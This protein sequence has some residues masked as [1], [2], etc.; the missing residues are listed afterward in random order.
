MNINKII[1][2]KFTLSYKQRE[3]TNVKCTKS[4]RI[5]LTSGSTFLTLTVHVCGMLVSP[6]KLG[7]IKYVTLLTISEP[8]LA[9][10]VTYITQWIKQIDKT[11]VG[12]M[13]I[14]NFY[15]LLANSIENWAIGVSTQLEPH[16]GVWNVHWSRPIEHFL[17]SF[18]KFYIVLQANIAI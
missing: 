18:T 17:N 6:G 8:Q 3:L 11:D 14:T 10:T 2:K 15:M 7:L 4:S 1:K 12:G 16:P 5:W 13:L 9:V